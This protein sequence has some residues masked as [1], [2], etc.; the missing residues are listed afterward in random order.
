MGE[1][2]SIECDGKIGMNCGNILIGCDG[3]GEL[4]CFGF[5]FGVFII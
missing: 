1:G 2:C 3:F 5:G 4:G